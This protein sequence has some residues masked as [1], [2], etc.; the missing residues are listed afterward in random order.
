MAGDAGGVAG[1][2]GV[3]APGTARYNQVASAI[4]RSG[5]P[6]AVAVRRQPLVAS[7]VQQDSWYKKPLTAVR[8]VALKKPLT[9][10]GVVAP[11]RAQPGQ[12]TARPRFRGGGWA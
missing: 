8:V 5:G 7:A 1:V 9:A 3:H 2:E 10:V 11:T 12:W 6:G 4:L